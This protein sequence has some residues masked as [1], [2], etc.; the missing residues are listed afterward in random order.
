[1]SGTVGNVVLSSTNGQN[2][3]RSKAFNQKDAN[4]VAQQK[5]RDV[6]KK[7][8]DEYTSLSSYIADGFPS[9]PQSQS[10][11][12]AF[13][14]ANL[15]NAVDKSGEFPVFDYS[16]MILSKGSLQPVEVLE[17]TIAQDG[18]QVNYQPFSE[19]GG[20]KADDVVIAIL[21]TV[22]GR[23]VVGEAVWTIGRGFNLCSVIERECRTDYV[24]VHDGGL[25]RQNQS[26]K[27]GL[28]KHCV[29]LLTS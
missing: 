27:I 20:A 16:K 19:N 7:T 21:K 24:H 5:H 28:C 18:I 29:R 1:M 3:V 22:E 17:A 10:C 11:Y 26:F 9:R 6:F 2:V 8:S 25:C 13:M 14:A 23:C 4:S 15:S 12:N